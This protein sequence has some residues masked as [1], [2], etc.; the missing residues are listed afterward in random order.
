MKQMKQQLKQT[1][2]LTLYF[3]GKTICL[4][5]SVESF[6]IWQKCAKLPRSFKILHPGILVFSQYF[7]L[8]IFN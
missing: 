3:V 2:N 5:D 8:R 6:M 7:I 4:L 1:V